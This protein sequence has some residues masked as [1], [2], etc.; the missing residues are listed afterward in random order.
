[1]ALVLLPWSLV[2]QSRHSGSVFPQP[3]SLTCS[4]PDQ[5]ARKVRL[6]HHINQDLTPQIRNR[7]NSTLKLLAL[8][9]KT[10]I[11]QPARQNAPDKEGYRRYYLSYSYS[12]YVLRRCEVMVLPCEVNWSRR[13]S[14]QPFDFDDVV[15]QD[16]TEE[17]VLSF[18]TPGGT[19]IISLLSRGPER[20][21]APYILVQAALVI[22]FCA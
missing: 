19:P 13:V 8:G 14:A 16:P 11:A 10:R 20:R 6:C 18:C 15:L 4:Y 5:D 21:R 1:M 3:W 17:S 12:Y 2:A 7:D 22:I 9:R